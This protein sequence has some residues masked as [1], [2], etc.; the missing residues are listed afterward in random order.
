MC[1]VF[2]SM[3]LKDSTK[4]KWDIHKAANGDLA[5]EKAAVEQMVRMMWSRYCTYVLQL[6]A[7]KG[8]DLNSMSLVKALGDEIWLQLDVD[9]SK[10]TGGGI[11]RTL[12]DAIEEGVDV[13]AGEG[14]H[15][16][17]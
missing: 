5:A 11:L 1:H 13:V 14:L 2:I 16:G 8:F 3:D 17:L 6:L 7:N 12:Q 4:T 10:D 9:P 15:D